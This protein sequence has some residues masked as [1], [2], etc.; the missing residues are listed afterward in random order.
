MRSTA[1]MFKKTGGFPS[2]LDSKIEGI[3]Y[4]FDKRD[5]E[6]IEQVLVELDEDKS[7]N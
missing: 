1:G 5:N 7:L 2:M 3:N 6:E 4:V